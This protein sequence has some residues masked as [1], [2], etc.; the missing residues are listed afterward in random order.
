[1]VIVPAFQAA[2]GD[3]VS[4]ND[5]TSRCNIGTGPMREDGMRQLVEDGMRHSNEGYCRPCHSLVTMSC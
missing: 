3:V 2:G 1:M 5:T 4:V